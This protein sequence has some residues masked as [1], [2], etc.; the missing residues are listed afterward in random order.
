MAKWTLET[1][2]ASALQYNT[3]TEWSKNAGGAYQAAQ[4]L[5]ILDECCQHM[6]APNQ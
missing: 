5:G 3:R 2:K 4:R 1:C 6:K